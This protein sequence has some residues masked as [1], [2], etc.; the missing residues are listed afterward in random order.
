MRCHPD[1]EHYIAWQI[2]SYATGIYQPHIPICLASKPEQPSFGSFHQL[3]GVIL[4]FDF[5]IFNGLTVNPTTTSFRSY[6]KTLIRIKIVGL[7]TRSFGS[8]IHLKPQIARIL[9][10]LVG[11]KGMAAVASDKA[12]GQ[13]QWEFSW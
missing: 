12:D 3:L 4:S 11:S 6:Y 7:K 1:L 13:T 8:S 10:Q 2:H 5:L 9:S